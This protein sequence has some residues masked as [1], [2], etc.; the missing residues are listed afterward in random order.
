MSR[1]GLDKALWLAIR[2]QPGE[3]DL[4]DDE[5]RALEAC[6]VRALYAFGAIPFLVYQY[7]LG[8]AGGFS[9]EFVGDYVKQLAGLEPVDTAT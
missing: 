8:R 3:T 9:F 2:G 7:A 6:D 5:R 1:Y 4:T